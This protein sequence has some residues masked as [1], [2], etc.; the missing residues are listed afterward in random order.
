MNVTLLLFLGNTKVILR[1]FPLLGNINF[2]CYFYSEFMC[3][4]LIHSKTKKTHGKC[5][6][7]NQDELLFK[8]LSFWVW[9]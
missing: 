1:F 6:A 3:A 2:S 4:I 9:L 8:K 7:Y 5:V